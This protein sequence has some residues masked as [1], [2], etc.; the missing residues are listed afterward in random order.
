MLDSH[1]DLAIPPET[2]FLIFPFEE[3]LDPEV[4]RDR[5]FHAITSYPPESPGWVDFQIPAEDFRQKLCELQPFA[6]AEGLRIFYR[7]YADRFH[8]SRWG[9]KTPLYCRHL[10]RIEALLPEARF[11]HLIRDGR[12]AAISLRKQWFSPGHEIGVQARYWRDNVKTAREQGS[13]CRHYLEVRYEDLVRNTQ[14]QLQRICAFLDLDY[15]PGMLRYYEGA[16]RR[17][18]EHTGRSRAH[19]SVAVT[20]EARR[21]QQAQT[22]YPPDASRIGAWRSALPEEDCREF[23][24]IAGDLLEELGY[25]TC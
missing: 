25:P 17:L 23:Q 10:R 1:P 8:K 7:M 14:T 11:V 15:H 9:D 3:T 13:A 5:F 19:G 2:G 22:K 12:D 24:A 6:V 16:S 18:Q 21:Q 4:S 20:P